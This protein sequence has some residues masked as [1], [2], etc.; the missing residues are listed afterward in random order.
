MP[1]WF[2]YVLLVM[3]AYRLTRLVVKDDFPPVLWLRDRLCGGWRP[4]TEREWA[5][6][7][8]QPLAQPKPWP[9]RDIDDTANRYVYR[10]TWVPHWLAELVSCPWCASAYVSGALVALTVFTVSLPAPVL[11]W[12]A[13]WAG[14]ALLTSREWA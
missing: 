5:Q 7:R 4:L 6:L 12:L 1:V 8:A 3:S 10:W 14:A 11:V 9:V 2:V 13:V